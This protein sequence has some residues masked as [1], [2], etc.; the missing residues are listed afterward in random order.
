L[1]AALALRWV[2][3]DLEHAARQALLLAGVVVLLGLRPLSAVHLPIRL[4][5]ALEL[6]LQLGLRQYLGKDGRVWTLGDTVHAAGAAGG[7]VLGDL[8]RDV[9]EVAQRRRAGRHQRTGQCG[10]GRQVFLAPAF[11]VAANH[12]L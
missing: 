12:A 5:D 4:G 8:R 1:G 7:N 10:V 9:A 2:D 3:D 6:F 11:L